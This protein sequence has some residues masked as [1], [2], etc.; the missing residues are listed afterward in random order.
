M[1]ERQRSSVVVT[2][3]SKK[4]S[5]FH[6]NIPHRGAVV[7]VEFQSGLWCYVREYAL[8]HGFLPFFSTLPLTA[9]QLP[10]LKAGLY[11]DLWCYDSEPAPMTFVGRFPFEDEPES[12][13]EP[14]YTAPDVMENC[15]TIH[16]IHHGLFRLR[17]TTD[18]KEISGMRLQRR[19]QP[20]E[21]DQLLRGKAGEWP[22]IGAIESRA[23]RGEQDGGGHPASLRI[24]S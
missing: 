15:Y 3:M 18:A 1:A 8:C 24:S 2:P 22:I 9:D 7:A 17:K 16:E 10:T 14:C 19:Y 6:Q 4:R 23:S 21:F 13:G 12:R 5:P 11:F 20:H